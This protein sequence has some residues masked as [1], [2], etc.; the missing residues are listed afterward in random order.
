MERREN[1]TEIL[2][3]LAR[4][5]ERSKATHLAIESLDNRLEDHMRD[6]EKILD[7]HAGRLRAVEQK[8]AWYAGA[9]A[10]GGALVATLGRKLVG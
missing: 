1:D 2:S 9:A 7:D 6:E 3:T 10:A 8:Q 5:D 4:L